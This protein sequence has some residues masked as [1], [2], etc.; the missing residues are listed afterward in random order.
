M[1][2]GLL[3][4]IAV[5]AALLP[6]S[7]FAGDW[8]SLKITSA[9]RGRDLQ[10]GDATLLDV[11]LD[12]QS[13]RQFAE[14]TTRHLGEKVDILIDGKVVMQPRLLSPIKGGSLRISSPSAGEIDALIAKLLDG[15]SV[16]SVE[17]TD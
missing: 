6:A 4:S 14:W 12:D 16:L 13:S 7:C 5:C 11:R 9:A 1:K 3:A 15:R 10:A 8:L 2:P 17:G